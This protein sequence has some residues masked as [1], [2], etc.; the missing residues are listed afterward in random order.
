MI[1][2]RQHDTA[3]Y[4]EDALMIGA[5]PADLTGCTV[6][7]CLQRIPAGGVVIRDAEVVTPATGAVRYLPEAADV[8]T[9]GEYRVEWLVTYPDNT[10]LTFPQRGPTKL[11][12]HPALA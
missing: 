11:V 6:R 8:E 7:I 12:I 9:P 4:I 3:Q 2:L 10:R 1:F 5:D